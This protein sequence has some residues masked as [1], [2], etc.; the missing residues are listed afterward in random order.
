MA[1]QLTPEMK[2]VLNNIRKQYVNNNKDKIKQINNKWLD[3]Q[4]NYQH[5]YYLEKVK[6]TDVI[7]NRITNLTEEE[8]K[9]RHR[10]KNNINGYKK[11][12][13]KGKEINLE[14]LQIFEEKLQFLENKIKNQE[15]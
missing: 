2:L 4:D 1:T 14:K 7:K 9:E 13:E 11:R 3:K 6:K 15:N 12:A 10:L 8:K 5:K